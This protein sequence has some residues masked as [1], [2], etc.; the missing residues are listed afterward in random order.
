MKKDS[1]ILTVKLLSCGT[2]KV[3]STRDT[4]V[5]L[6]KILDFSGD[7]SLFRNTH[8]SNVKEPAEVFKFVCVCVCVFARMC[9]CLCLCV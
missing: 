9:L 5:S 7:N 6:Q 8:C 1:L 3:Q 2:Y 4:N